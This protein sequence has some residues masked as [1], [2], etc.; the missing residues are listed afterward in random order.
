MFDM[1]PYYLTALLNILGPVKRYAGAASIAIPERTITSQPSFGQKI[2]VETP[3]HVCG[4]MEF[5]NGCTGTII[6]TFATHFPTAGPPITI[7][8][9]EGTMLVPDPNG[10]DGEVKVRRPG[11]ED[12]VTAPYTSPTGYGRAV[13]LADMCTAVASGRPHRCS[14]EQAFAV[15]DMMAGF[16]DSSEASAFRVP[17]VAYQ[18]PAPMV[19][20]LPFGVLDE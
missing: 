19:T 12:W 17:E 13:G 11:D 5:E 7:Y 2:T 16:L 9:T 15:L 3:D 14:G 6:Q 4:L 1:G 8:G 18:R 10:F 20:G